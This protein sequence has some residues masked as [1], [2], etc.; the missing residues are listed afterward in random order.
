MSLN[1]I[2]TGR[3]IHTPSSGPRGAGRTVRV[4]TRLEMGIAAAW[5][6]LTAAAFVLA[7]IALCLG[8]SPIALAGCAYVVA[9]VCGGALV[10]CTKIEAHITHRRPRP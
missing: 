9:A 6:M 5:A 3:P 10:V 1:L 8:K 7:A 4:L 2:A